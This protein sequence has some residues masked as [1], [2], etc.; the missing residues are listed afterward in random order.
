MNNEEKAKKFD[1]LVEHLIELHNHYLHEF[2]N[3][4]V[5]KFLA[6][7]IEEVLKRYIKI[8]KNKWGTITNKIDGEYIVY[9]QLN[10]TTKKVLNCFSENK[11]LEWLHFNRRDFRKILKCC[12][13]EQNHTLGYCWKSEV[14]TIKNNKV[15]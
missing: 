5:N 10:K 11:L 1:K 14:I 9:Y 15:K 8:E 7:K 3:C 2:V 13:G 6:S 4:N 12:K